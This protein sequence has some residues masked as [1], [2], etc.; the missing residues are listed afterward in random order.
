VLEGYTAS[1][2]LKQCTSEVRRSPPMVL[3]DKNHRPMVVIYSR[4]HDRVIYLW[5]AD[6]DQVVIRVADSNCAT[7]AEDVVGF[8]EL[9]RRLVESQEG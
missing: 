2:Q 9:C 8:D 6:P 3:V 4:M 7:I 5:L 1:A